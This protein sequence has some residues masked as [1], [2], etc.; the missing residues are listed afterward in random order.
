MGSMVLKLYNT[1]SRKKEEF[2]PIS[3]G[4]VRIYSCGQTIYEDMHIGNARQYAN[5]DVLNRYLG[6]K[7]Y[8]VF[9]VLNVTDVGH[10]TDDADQGEDKVEKS[11]REKD[12]EPR[13]LVTQLVRLFYREMDA[14]NIKRHNINPRATGH[15][16][17]M[18]QAVEKIMDSGYAY[19]ENGSVYFDVMKFEKEHGYAEMAGVDIQELKENA[20]GRL[21]DEERGEKKNPLDFA[22]WIKAE[23]E[24]LMKWSS[25]WG[26]GYPGWHIECSVMSTNYLGEKFDIHTGGVDH[27]FPHHPNERAQDYAMNDLGEEPVNYWIHGDFIT[28]GGEKMAKSEGNFVTVSDA[29]EKYGGEVLR[30]FFSSSHYRKQID[31]NEEAI[32][33]SRSKLDR[34]YNTLWEIENSEGG[35]EENLSGDIEKL[36]DNFG[37]AMDDDLDTPRAM[38]GIMRFAKEVNKN[39]DNRKEILDEVGE[40]IRELGGVLGLRLDREEKTEDVEGLMEIL[41][42]VR[43]DLRDVGNYR[44]ADKIRDRLEEIGIRLEDEGE[45][46]VWKKTP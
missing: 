21:D 29:L 34:L 38:N 11:A 35:G 17:E 26:E 32:E 31:Y 6:W 9:H 15:I 43:E 37:E 13:E 12:L 19:K 28:V 22:L 18:I 33:N 27:I 2:K 4:K 40:T 8:D 7:G 16:H 30:M 39:L 46:T 10:L 36:R 45:G 23:P 44:E 42:D 5:W 1:M 24:H 41:V 14:L 3:E 20:S 25:P